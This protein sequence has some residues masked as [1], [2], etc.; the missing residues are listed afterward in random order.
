MKS[1]TIKATLEN[2]HRGTKGEYYELYGEGVSVC[3]KAPTPAFCRALLAKNPEM[4]DGILEVYRGDSLAYTVKS[5]E[6]HSKIQYQDND[7]G[8]RTMK[9]IPFPQQYFS[10]K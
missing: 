9:F 4:K 1:T 2:N 5:I 10:K 6:K 8:L 7:K 3:G